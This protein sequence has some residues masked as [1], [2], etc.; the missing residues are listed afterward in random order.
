MNISDQGLTE[1]R[2]TALNVS[3]KTIGTLL[4]MS[5]YKASAVFHKYG[6]D[7]SYTETSLKS[8]C[9]AL[10]VDCEQVTVE[11]LAI[12]N[13]GSRKGVDFETWPL[14]LLLRYLEKIHHRYAIE[15]MF[16]I[17]IWLDQY[18][19]KGWAWRTE[20]IGVAEL[21]CHGSRELSFHLREEEQ[22]LFPMVRTL[23]AKEGK[24]KRVFRAAI[25]L[26]KME[27][28]LLEHNN[29]SECFN[30]I[31]KL[32]GHYS[33]PS[34]HD[35]S[36][37]ICCRSLREFHEDLLFHMHLE[38]NILAPKARDLARLLN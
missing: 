17:Q 21:F 8:A 6:L 20:M 38:N 35:Q 36:F 9:E 18:K 24:S 1:P 34:D 37:E 16:Q 28:I 26:G 10:Q 15:K 29:L 4:A 5:N 13:D 14:E 25:S 19:Q 7:F 12:L 11:V 27:A 23:L 32:T 2:L 3:Q 31:S 22:C 33:A 30:H